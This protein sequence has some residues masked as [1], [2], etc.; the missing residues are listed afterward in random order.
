MFR[1]NGRALLVL[2]VVAVLCIAWAEAVPQNNKD[3]G[4]KGGNNRAGQTNGGSNGQTGQKCQGKNQ[5]QVSKAKDGS[6]I[7]ADCVQIK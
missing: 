3:N 7:L 5:R 6:T 2:L 1:F 4:K